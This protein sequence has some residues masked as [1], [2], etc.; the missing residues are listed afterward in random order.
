MFA[1]SIQASISRIDFVLL[2]PQHAFKPRTIHFTFAR[3]HNK[4]VGPAH[5]KGYRIGGLRGGPAGGRDGG[6]S[7]SRE[8]GV[9]E[10]GDGF[11]VGILSRCFRVVVLRLRRCVCGG[12][13]GW[14]GGIG[15]LGDITGEWASRRVLTG[16]DKT[17]VHELIKMPKKSFQPK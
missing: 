7:A 2:F 15:E 9:S 12:G 16:L 17:T 5:R 13:S 8:R 1:C 14:R 10:S 4:R 3:T 6:V 11:R